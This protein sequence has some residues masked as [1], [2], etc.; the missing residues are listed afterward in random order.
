[1]RSFLLLLGLLGLS[2]ASVLDRSLGIQDIQD[3]FDH[4]GDEILTH[5]SL[6][7]ASSNVQGAGNVHDVSLDRSEVEGG[8]QEEEEEEDRE[9]VPHPSLVNN[10]GS[11]LKVGQVAGVAVGPDDNPVVFHRGCHKWDG[12]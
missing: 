11:G 10:W 4:L 7:G 6:G 1:M 12:K 2:S 5:G 8:A 9:D 3:M